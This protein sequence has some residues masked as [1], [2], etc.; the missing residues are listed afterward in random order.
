MYDQP[1]AYLSKP[2]IVNLREGQL[3]TLTAAPSWKVFSVVSITWYHTYHDVSDL[4]YQR[5]VTNISKNETI[6][7]DWLN[8]GDKLNFL[9]S[10]EIEKGGEYFMTYGT[11]DRDLATK[12][13]IVRIHSTELSKPEISVRNPKTNEV[14]SFDTTYH[15]YSRVLQHHTLTPIYK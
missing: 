12:T 11:S 9:V 6:N 10:A 1:D 3:Y 5:Y 14:L 7:C 2:V 8:C 13:Y 4:Y 15:F